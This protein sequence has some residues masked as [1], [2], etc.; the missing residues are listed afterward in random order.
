LLGSAANNIFFDDALNDTGTPDYTVGGADYIDGRGGVDTLMFHVFGELSDGNSLGLSGVVVDMKNGIATDSAGNTD[1]FFNIENIVGTTMS[2][3]ILGDDYDNWIVTD[4]GNDTV[5]VGMG[6]DFARLGGDNDTVTL[7]ADGVWGSR[8]SATHMSDA[9]SVGTNERVSI[10]GKNRYEDVIWGEDGYDKVLLSD[11][12]DVLVVEDRY[13]GYNTQALVNST[14]TALN[15]HA[16]RVSGFEEVFAGGGDDV[17]DFTSVAYASVVSNGIKI[18]GEAGNDVLWASHGNDVL[19]GGDGDDILNGGVGDDTLTGG[20]G[21]DIYE[22][23][24]T[25]GH[26]TITDF[27]A[28][29]DVIHIYARKTDTKEV[30]MTGDTITWG[31]VEIQLSNVVTGDAL[32]FGDNIFWM[33]V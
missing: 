2:D 1:R 5:T 23:T 26:D 20:T 30:T 15:T 17:I 7:T 8:Y 18:Y 19:D 28:A 22:F 11:E 9:S 16:S 13:S 4:L 33:T 27:D 31:D 3:E 21:A 12:A 32:K 24:A 25:S 10:A 14:G 29:N 6:F